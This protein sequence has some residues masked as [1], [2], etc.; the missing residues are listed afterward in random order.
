VHE[1]QN[2]SVYANIAGASPLSRGMDGQRESRRTQVMA[3]PKI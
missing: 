1:E 2:G 3:G